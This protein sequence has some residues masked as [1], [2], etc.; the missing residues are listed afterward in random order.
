V[1]AKP[2]HSQERTVQ[3]VVAL[4]KH[5]SK[6]TLD[7]H[8]DV[9]STQI[10]KRNATIRDNQAARNLVTLTPGTRV[11]ITPDKIKPKYLGGHKGTVVDPDTLGPINQTNPA[12]Q[13]AIPVRLDHGRVRKFGPIVWVPA[14]CLRK[15]KDQTSNHP[16]HPT[17][18][19]IPS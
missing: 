7:K 19:H 4:C 2:K 13:K 6:G 17:P 15:L 3:Y 8:L 18:D 16:N 9:I 1:A 12:Y 10:N 5:I 14:A 11:M